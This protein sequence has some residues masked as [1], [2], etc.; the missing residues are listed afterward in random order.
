MRLF[1]CW[2][3]AAYFAATL[4]LSRAVP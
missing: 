1:A 4:V 2:I 3:R